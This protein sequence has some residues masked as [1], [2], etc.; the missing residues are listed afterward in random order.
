MVGR[1]GDFTRLF[2]LTKDDVSKV[3]HKVLDKVRTMKKIQLS[4]H[5][6]NDIISAKRLV[7]HVTS[8]V[9]M[10]IFYWCTV[11][12]LKHISINRLARH[13]ATV[14][15]VRQWVCT[16]GKWG[17]VLVLQLHH[18]MQTGTLPCWIMGLPSGWLPIT[19]L[20]MLHCQTQSM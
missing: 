6:N 8:P 4:A 1:H 11:A 10:I 12:F 20:S 9:S 5:L 13:I 15:F 19:V 3:V 14:T 17:T 16:A 2:N 7:K 18:Q